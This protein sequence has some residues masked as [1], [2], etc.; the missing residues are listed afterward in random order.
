MRRRDVHE[1]LADVLAVGE[2]IGSFVGTTT[3]DEYAADRVL[4]LA[5]ERQFEVIGE[6]V[7]RALRTEP[8]LV[9]RIPEAPAMIAFRNVLA[10]GYDVVSIEA[11]YENAK[12][13]LPV[14]LAKVRSVLGEVERP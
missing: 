2:E 8:H 13:K 1:A 6:A 7:S 11:V 14:L 4:S 12:T 9:D 3:F 5:V 10:H